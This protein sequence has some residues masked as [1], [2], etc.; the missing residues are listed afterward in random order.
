MIHDNFSNCM[1]QCQKVFI[2]ISVLSTVDSK[3]VAYHG[4]NKWQNEGFILER[5][6]DK[7]L[8]Y[9]KKAADTKSTQSKHG[10]VVTRNNG[11]GS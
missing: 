10:E 6:P 7:E 11:P 8:L 5:E 9:V 4:C 3:V 2:Q 1:N